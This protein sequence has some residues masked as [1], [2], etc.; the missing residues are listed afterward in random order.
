VY[1]IKSQPDKK[2]QPKKKVQPNKGMN[3]T[4]DNFDEKETGVYTWIDQTLYYIPGVNS[5]DALGIGVCRNIGRT[6]KVMTQ[7]LLN[8]LRSGR[9]TAWPTGELLRACL[10]FDLIIVVQFKA[11]PADR[12]VSRKWLVAAEVSGADALGDAKIGISLPSSVYKELWQNLLNDPLY[13]GGDK[14]PPSRL[15]K[16]QATDENSIK[17]NPT[18]NLFKRAEDVTEYTDVS[19]DAFLNA[20]EM[21]AV[22]GT[23]INYYRNQLISLKRDAPALL[24]AL[25]GP[26]NSAFYTNIVNMSGLHCV[27]RMFV[28]ARVTWRQWRRRAIY[29]AFLNLL[30]HSDIYAPSNWCMKRGRVEYEIARREAEALLQ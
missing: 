7:S 24:P 16:M 17:I 25:I 30:E 18:A 3:S 4:K 19:A 14:C 8:K 20:Q 28:L 27:K 22:Y 21:C 5:K 15:V 1:K 10:T 11:N 23:A 29:L 12:H 9:E 2:L 6:L 26:L 13:N